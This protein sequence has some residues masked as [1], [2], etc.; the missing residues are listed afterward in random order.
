[1]GQR[2]LEEDKPEYTFVDFVNELQGNTEDGDKYQDEEELC[3][4]FPQNTIDYLWEL[5][6]S[7][8]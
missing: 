7:L 5:Y 8:K 4:M 6:Q 2:V 3:A 1:M